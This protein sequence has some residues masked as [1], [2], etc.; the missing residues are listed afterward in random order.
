MT[1]PARSQGNQES[2][3]SRGRIIAL[4]A[5]PEVPDA[6]DIDRVHMVMRRWNAQNNAYLGFAKT[7]EEHI[8]M[9]SGRQW[10]RWS[11]LYGRF[12]DVLQFMSEDERR[13]R[14]R[15]V[16]DYL[17][18]WYT[19]TMAKAIENQTTISFQPATSDR[20]DAML[21]EVMDPVWKTLFHDMQMDARTIRMVGWQ[22]VA[23]EGYFVTRA[24]FTSGKK[25]Q[26]IAPATLRLDRGPGMSPIERDVDAAPYDQ[27]GNPLAQLVRNPDIES[28]DDPEA[29]GYDVTGEP[30][31]D[32]EGTPAVD[33]YCPLQ[34]RAQ[35]G[36]H[37][38]WRDKRWIMTESFMTPDQIGEQ[39]GVS[40]DADHYI[41]E[42]DSGPGYL[43]RMLF[44]AG[45]YGGFSDNQGSQLGTSSTATDARLEEGFSR[46]ITMWEK[47]IKGLS[48]PTDDMP[49]GGRLLVVAPGQDLVL[50]DSMRPFKTACAGPIRRAAF[51]DIPGRPQGTT[52]LERGVPLQKRLNRI[53]AHIAQHTNLCTDPILFVHEAA[54]IDSDEFVAKPGLVITHGY[55]GNGQPAYFLAP[56]ALSQDVWRHKNDVREQLF[57]ILAMAGNQ[58]A[59]PTATASGELVEQLRVNADRPLTPLTMNLA[60][61]LGEV[62]EDVMAILPTIWTEEKLISYAGQDNVVRT[63]KV[64]PDMLEGSINVRPNLESAAAESRDARRSRL[65]QLY[66]LGAFGDVSPTALPADRQKATAQLLQMINF[67]DLTRASRPGGIDR[68][69][70]EHNVGRL[71]RGDHAM[72]I[73]LLE[74][75]DF[76]VHRDVVANEMKAPEFLEFDKTIQ[77]EFDALL[78]MIEDAQDTQNM[79]QLAKKLPIAQA[80]AA[81]AGA[82]QTTAALASPPPGAGAPPGPTNA[83]G[84]PGAS[85]A[86]AGPPGRS[87][88]P[89]TASASPR[90][91]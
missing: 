51:I 84:S 80:T 25:R 65:I 68:V 67:P 10:D 27:K 33:V 2:P 5:D 41:G 40:C 38:P 74:V 82:V 69:M 44:G 42:D 43:E 54:G 52:L 63:V 61:A 48:D 60:I 78:H 87:N 4:R 47:P 34:V 15:P 79:N 36:Q 17:G 13:Y 45:Y 83:P 29:Y 14:M 28:D 7:V 71:V 59:T 18:Y 58:A 90:A 64:T 20:I 3:G 57:V 21:A 77:A 81:A 86:P 32:L 49:A 30:Y 26:L 50:W 23:G 72:D 8:R 9:L 24:D 46:V 89:P 6:L 62:A 19:L 16:M 66:Q 53:E 85:S 31:E 12:V 11:N 35:W 56:P 75:Y 1:S 39:F 73:P 88:G 70:A 22:L 91:A 76:D 37:I 55:N